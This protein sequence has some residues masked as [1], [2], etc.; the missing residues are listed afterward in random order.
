MTRWGARERFAAYVNRRDEELD[1]LFN[2]YGVDRVN[3]DTQKDY[4]LPLS[5][6]F[7]ARAKRL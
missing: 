6:F 1:S 7:R 5:L 2:R 4:V 3:I